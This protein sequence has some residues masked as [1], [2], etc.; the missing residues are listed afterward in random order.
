MAASRAP[1]QP[2]GGRRPPPPRVGLPL[3]ALAVAVWAV[4]VLRFGLP[5]PL[6]NLLLVP[7]GLAVV[8]WPPAAVRALVLL[9]ATGAFG[10]CLATPSVP[11]ETMARIAFQ[12]LAFAAALEVAMR[13]L[14]QRD[15]AVQ[16]LRAREERYRLLVETADVIPWEREL[17]SRRFR[18]VGPQAERLL[19]YPLERWYEPDFW[20]GR[21]HPEDRERAVAS[22]RLA[23]ERGEDHAFEYRML[24]ADGRVVWLR[25]VVSVVRAADRLV[26]QRGVMVDVSEPRRLELALQQAQRLESL[27]VLAGGIA[28]EFNNLLT[29]ILGNASLLEDA[30]AGDGRARELASEIERSAQRAAELTRQM[31]AFAGQGA[32]AARVRDLSEIAADTLARFSPD[33]PPRIEVVFERCAQPLPIRADRDQLQQ[34][35]LNLARNAAEAIGPAGGRIWLRTARAGAE[36]RPLAHALT[37]PL[38]G[39]G[40]SAEIEIEDDGPGMDEA[41]LARCFD[42]FFSTRAP[43]RGLGLPAVLGTVR[44]H[45]GS[46]QLE[47]EPGSGLRICVRLPLAEGA[48]AADDARHTARA[49]SALRPRVLLVDDEDSVRQLAARVLERHGYEVEQFRDGKRALERLD[50]SPG[51]DAIVLDMT[52]PGLSGSEVLRSLRER[53]PALPVL[54]I[55]GFSKQGFDPALFAD[56]ALAFLDKPFSAAELARHLEALLAS[57]GTAGG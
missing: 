4:L 48:P 42:P 28:H 50:T 46:L 19:G 11:A 8:G 52:M 30:L 53:W 41:T 45:G 16:E 55:S 21:L 20:E 44:S 27:G 49:P 38:P 7:I 33:L 15:A 5:P 18:Y 40:A 56:P 43:G 47:T 14:Q 10:V 24:A 23:S 22:G 31:Q 13:L 2:L 29:G 39:D 51:F 57:V 17:P 35:I 25:E 3:F 34:L 32:L 37:A 1:L 26:G 54:L 6:I 9:L 12:L 36:R